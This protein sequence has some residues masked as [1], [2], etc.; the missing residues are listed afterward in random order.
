MKSIKLIANARC[1]SPATF[2]ACPMLIQKRYLNLHEFQS[3]QLMAKFGINT[4][5]FYIAHRARDVQ[6][7]AKKLEATQYVVKAQILAGGRGKGV[8]SNGFKGG[9]HVVSDVNLILGKNKLYL[10]K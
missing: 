1:L 10:I 7:F 5:P 4:Q 2:R 6:D 8:F 3:K 9:V